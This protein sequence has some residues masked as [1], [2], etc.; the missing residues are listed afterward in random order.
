MSNTKHLC[1]QYVQIA[2]ILTEFNAITA[3]LMK[4]TSNKLS[5]YK[6][7]HA[8]LCISHAP[9]CYVLS[10][11]HTLPHSLL[12]QKA[13]NSSICLALYSTTHGYI[14]FLCTIVT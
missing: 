5:S 4:K 1:I 12:K 8:I 3:K 10:S 11:D 7:Y 2:H 9:D 14:P 6:K 13:F